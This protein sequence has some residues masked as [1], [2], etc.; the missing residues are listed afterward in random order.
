MTI[1]NNFWRDYKDPLE[2]KR[3][4]TIDEMLCKHE[5]LG[6]DLQNLTCKVQTW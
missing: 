3:K 5:D 4:T 1:K 6:S 2:S